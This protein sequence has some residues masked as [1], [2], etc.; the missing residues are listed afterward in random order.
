MK[1]L[2]TFA[3]VLAV[4]VTSGCGSLTMPDGATEGALCQ[5]WGESLPTRSRSDTEQTQAEIQVAY[6]DFLGSCPDWS[7]LVP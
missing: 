7:H 5:I 4:T 3:A 6:A 2:M 1:T